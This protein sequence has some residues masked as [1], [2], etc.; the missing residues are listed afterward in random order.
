MKVGAAEEAAIIHRLV[1][2]DPRLTTF[3]PHVISA[4]NDYLVTTRY[5][6]DLVCSIE[7]IVIVLHDVAT[8]LDMCHSQGLLHLDVK[9]ANILL[10]RVRRRAR[11]IDFNISRFLP[12]GMLQIFLTKPVGTRW[13]MSPEVLILCGYEVS[14]VSAASDIYSLGMTALVYL[15]EPD[16]VESLHQCFHSDILDWV[17]EAMMRLHNRCARM[18]RNGSY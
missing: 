9:P 15:S 8:A 11:L 14:F 2:S 5:P 6:S 18:R 7:D 16:E 13:Y 3:L 10:D 4:T 1:T 17:D 12:P